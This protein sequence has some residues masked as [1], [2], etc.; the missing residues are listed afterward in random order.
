MANSVKLAAPRKI[1][2]SFQTYPALLAGGGRWWPVCQGMRVWFAYKLVQLGAVHWV[3]HVPRWRIFRL[4]WWKYA[5]KVLRKLNESEDKGRISR[6]VINEWSLR[7]LVVIAL[8]LWQVTI[9]IKRRW[10]VAYDALVNPSTV[11]THFG[12]AFNQFGTAFVHV[13]M[14]ITMLLNVMLMISVG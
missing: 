12:I 8:I 7:C 11:F 1:I 5:Y 13:A 2:Q 4:N 14:M 3:Q 9:I 6:D 10:I